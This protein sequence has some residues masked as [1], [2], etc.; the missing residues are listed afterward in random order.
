MKN[1]LQMGENLMRADGSSIRLFLHNHHFKSLRRGQMSSKSGE[2]LKNLIQ[3]SQLSCQVSSEH[4]P[5]S[6]H[7]VCSQPRPHSDPDGPSPPRQVQ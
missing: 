7:K 5:L 6:F 2:S 1:N 4:A 3:L